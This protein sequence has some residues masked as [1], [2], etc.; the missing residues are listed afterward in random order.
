M[1][2]FRLPATPIFFGVAFLY[3]NGQIKNEPLTD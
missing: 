2:I 1:R 3:F